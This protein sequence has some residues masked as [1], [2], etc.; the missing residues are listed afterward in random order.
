MNRC[1][2]VIYWEEYFAYKYILVE[3]FVR[4][5]LVDT[6]TLLLVCSFGGAPTL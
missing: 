1:H 4:A 2:L 5:A 6:H 3:S